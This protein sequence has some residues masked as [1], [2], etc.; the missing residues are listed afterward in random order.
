M[1]CN[2]VD[3]NTK[4]RS[5]RSKEEGVSRIKRVV[6]VATEAGVPDFCVN[7]RTDILGYGGSIEDAIGRGQAYL[8]AGATTVYVWGP[9]GRGVSGEEVKQ[10]VAALGGM[11][12]VRMKLSPGCMGVK[13]LSEM[14]VARTSVGPDLFHEAMKAYKDALD[15][16]VR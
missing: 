2:L 7:A 11:L 3:L 10:L 5:L 4:E 15:A 13:E 12:N 9:E 8:D 16:A 6:A 1:G 14:G